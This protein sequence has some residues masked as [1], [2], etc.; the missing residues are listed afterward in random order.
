MG[1]PV[2]HAPAAL[3]STGDDGD[4]LS[5]QTG[6][7]FYITGQQ[8]LRPTTWLLATALAVSA[9]S[10][11]AY[12]Q[13]HF[14]SPAAH[15]NDKDDP[16]QVDVIVAGGHGKTGAP[17]QAGAGPTTVHPTIIVHLPRSGAQVGF[18][19][20]SPAGH[21]LYD[22]LAAFNHGSYAEL[23][24]S[25]GGKAPSASVRAQLELR[26]R[27]GGFSLLSAREIEPG[28]LVFRLCDQTPS[29]TEVLG[30]LQVRATPGAATILSFDLTAVAPA[31]KDPASGAAAPPISQ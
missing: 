11:T 14:H 6:P 7:S 5:Q 4:R 2:E 30:S 24:K 28:T 23:A 13:S 10:L 26:R 18:L 22:W 9:L 29:A 3:A 15:Q 16:D 31:H 8:R 21:V 1:I 12:L 19:P 20:N 25:W 17:A 27:T